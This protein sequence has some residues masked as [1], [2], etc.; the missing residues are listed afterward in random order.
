[1]ATG[2]LTATLNSIGQ[3]A[4]LRFAD[5]LNESQR[6]RLTVQLES[7]DLNA[8]PG[9]V[10]RYVT[11]KYAPPIPTHFEPASSLPRIPG[12]PTQA[13]LYKKARVRGEELIREG[14][15]AAFLV[16]G[17]Q[18]TRLGYDGPKGE[19]PV[20]PIRKK[21]LFQVFAEQ[22]IAVGRKYGKPVPWY[23]M[24]SDTNDA[25]TRAFFQK[26]HYFGLNPADVFFFQQ[27][28]MPAFSMD[29]QL[30]LAEKDSLALSPGGNGDCFRSL[31]RTGAIADMKRRGITHLSYFNVDNPLARCV[32]E[33][34]LGLHD[35]TGSDM[36]SKAVPKAS[37]QERVGN[38]AIADGKLQ[39]I[40]YSDMPAA[41]ASETN[42]DGSLKYLCASIGIHAIR[43]DFVE[44]LNAGGELQLPWHRAEK[45]MPC[46][47]NAGNRVK[48][49][50]INAVKLEQ[51][52][53]D[54]IPLASNPLVFMTE[55]S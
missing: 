55:R 34:F 45:K 13:A 47:D 7:L 38:F 48:P 1:M 21:P 50:K 23:I 28:M 41:V 40:E 52:V 33:L 31:M 6:S 24:T 32:D 2:E 18:G 39:V 42:P 19:Y 44:R 36:S 12:N 17:G 20:T 16:A 29:G 4:A 15:V 11:G 9:L 8:I 46:V 27:G 3:S 25:A 37:A 54:A 22:L 10:A 5:S 14:A 51:F 35:V 43:V 49:D 53:F 30:L 26:H